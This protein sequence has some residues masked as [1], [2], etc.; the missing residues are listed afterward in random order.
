[1]QTLAQMNDGSTAA[2]TSKQRAS[3][4]VFCWCALWRIKTGLASFAVESA[5]SSGAVFGTKAAVH[6]AR[7]EVLTPYMSVCTT[8]RVFAVLL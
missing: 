6:I 8:L 4:E 5:G 3:R 1:M 7:G 2:G